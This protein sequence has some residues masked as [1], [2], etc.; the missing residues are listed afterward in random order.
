MNRRNEN[1]DPLGQYARQQI[2][3]HF[4]AFIETEGRCLR[5]IRPWHRGLYAESLVYF[6]DRVQ[7]LK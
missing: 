7:F 3:L 1:T 2:P 4:V 5:V 6:P